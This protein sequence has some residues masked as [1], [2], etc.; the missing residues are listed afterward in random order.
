MTSAGKTKS[1]S[2]GWLFFVVGLCL[3]LLSGCDEQNNSVSLSGYTMGTTWHITYL[4]ESAS[5]SQEHL[6]ANVEAILARVDASMSTYRADS[7]ISLVSAADTGEWTTVSTDFLQVLDAALSIGAQSR[8]AYDIT[9]G[10]LVDRWGFGPV[11]NTA[12]IPSSEEIELLRN[13]VGQ[14]RLQIDRDVPALLKSTAVAL[15]FSSI[16]KG[17]AVDRLAEHL[18]EKQIANFLVEVGGEMRLAGLSARGDPWR[19]AI[20]Q[21]DIVGRNVA[22]AL[23]LTDSAVATSGDYRN[24]FEMDGKR[25]SHTI[26][27][28]TGFPVAHDLVSVTVIHSSAM[29]ADGW[30]TALT[31]LGAAE[32]MEVALEQELAVYFIRRDEDGFISSSSEAFEPYLQQSIAVE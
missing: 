5:P 20:E 10:P 29:L 28:R 16:A 18:L 30:A 12:G 11:E 22:R 19:I 15:D 24:F 7:E 32:A 6:Q 8:G 21:P 2:Q 4:P 9:V 14:D 31:V 23:S 3:V 17:F 26:D 13:R 25:Y 27:P 1:H